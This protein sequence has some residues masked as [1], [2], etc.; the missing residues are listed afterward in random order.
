MRTAFD[1]HFSGLS[2]ALKRC[3]NGIITALKRPFNAPSAAFKCVLNSLLTTLALCFNLALIAF[4]RHLNR[5]LLA[6][7]CFALSTFALAQSQAQ[8]LVT[9][10]DSSLLAPAP[11]F[12]ESLSQQAAIFISTPAARQPSRTPFFKRI[13]SPIDKFFFGV[14]TAYI[15]RDDYIFQAL[16]QNIYSHES[17]KIR[18]KDGNTIGFR[19]DASLKLGPYIG[20]SFIFV[21]LSFDILHLGQADERREMDLS[22]YTLPFVIDIYYRKSGGSYNIYGANLGDAID[23][24][25][26]NGAQFRGFT[27]SVKGFDLYYIFNH[28]RFSYPA[29]YNQSSQQRH[30]AGTILA[31]F[32]FTRHKLSIDWD[33]LTNLII[34]KTGAPSEDIEEIVSNSL[35]FNKITYTDISL[36]G[37]YAYNWVFARNWLLGASASIGLSY[38]QTISDSER[39]FDAFRLSFTNLRDFKFSDLTFDF[40]GRLG[41]VY[42]T[43]KWFAGLSAIIHSYNYST[44]NFSTNNSFGTINIYAGLNFGRKKK[45]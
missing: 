17:Y 8:S 25:R 18:S 23:I 40:M 31:G 45:Q 11:Q 42:N 33:D 2:F 3:Y 35:E 29:A 32:G 44:D 38:K 19:P 5:A 14:D 39:G 9:P 1:N 41:L 4:N 7:A 13:A 24:T 37:G 21:G 6:L 27:S 34:E 15:H 12:R 10:V 30:S 26:L 43:G 16:F 20:W 22:L 28:R 36:S